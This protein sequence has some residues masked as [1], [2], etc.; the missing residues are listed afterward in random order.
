[1]GAANKDGRETNNRSA[2][3]YLCKGWQRL[4]TGVR[5]GLFWLA[6]LAAAPFP[7]PAL[8]NPSPTPTHHHFSRGAPLTALSP[9]ELDSEVS[10]VRARSPFPVARSLSRSLSPAPS[11]SVC[12]SPAPPSPSHRL[13]PSLVLS[14]P[15]FFLPHP[16]SSSFP[17]T[18]SLLLS[19][20]LSLSLHTYISIL[21]SPHPPH[22]CCGASGY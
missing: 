13:P 22:T 2:S 18:L 3:V 4:G 19:L 21:V 7:Q 17:P 11:P 9:G 14:R 16:P 12:P 1:M 15:L 20:S 10:A 5:Q 8:P 6:R